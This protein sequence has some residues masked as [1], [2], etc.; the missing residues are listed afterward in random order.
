MPIFTKD[1]KKLL[2]RH[3]P[4]TGGTSVENTFVSSGWDM[5]FFNKK[6]VK[7]CCP[8][9]YHTKLL[10]FYEIL[11]NSIILDFTVTR[12][13]WYRLCSE[14]F[15]QNKKNKKILNN[16]DEFMKVI[17]EFFIKNSKIYLKQEKEFLSNITGFCKNERFVLDNHLRPQHYYIDNNTKVYKFEKMLDFWEDIQKQINGLHDLQK[18]RTKNSVRDNYPSYYAGK[19]TEFKELYLHLYEEDHNSLNYPL[20]F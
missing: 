13:P 14:Y 9:H 4:K 8:Q 5:T 12:N 19:N 17:E 7:P 3:I 6:T 18:A 16:P 1:G 11:D 20:P 10:N 15:H 2:F